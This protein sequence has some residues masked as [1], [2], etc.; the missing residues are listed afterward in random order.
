MSTITLTIT[1]CTSSLYKI[2]RSYRKDPQ[3]ES[4]SIH[5]ASNDAVLLEVR[6]YS[7]QIGYEWMDG[8]C[9]D[10]EAFY[11]K[12][13]GSD[14]WW[15]W[16]SYLYLYYEFAEGEEMVLK[17]R[18]DPMVSDSI[19]RLRRPSIGASSEWLYKMGEVP[20]DWY[21]ESASTEGWSSGA[22]GSFSGATNGIQL[23][24]Q[25]FTIDSISEVKGVV[26]NIR[27][28]Y[29]CV[30]YLNGHEAWRNGV[31]GAVSV[32]SVPTNTY[33]EL[34]YRVITLPGRTMPTVD[35][36]A[37]VNLLKQGTNTIAIAIVGPSTDLQSHFD[38]IVRLMPTQAESHIWEFRVDRIDVQNAAGLFDMYYDSRAT[39]TS[40]TDNSV[41]I[42]LSNDRREWVS[43]IQIQNF[44]AV[45]TQTVTQFKLYGRNSGDWILLKDVSGLIYTT[46][47]QKKRIYLNN[48][49]PYNQFKFENLKT[50]DPNSCSWIIQSLDLYADNTMAESTELVYPASGEAFKDIE[51]AEIIPEG[52]GYMDFQITPALPAGIH[53]DPKLAGSLE[54]PRRRVR[55]Q[56][57]RSLRRSWLE[58]P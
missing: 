6:D 8:I 49:T 23:Y 36:P 24:R 5:D 38:A 41:T 7:S 14:E 32:N 44:Y 33:G 45:N 9:I 25:S 16:N 17:A 46:A 35:S 54:Q 10:E 34:M 22:M 3:N 19:H 18:Y 1:E 56:R 27:Y 12:V 55:S 31:D 52:E 2:V 11:V 20:S 51:I 26:L 43:S 48:N 37:S 50:G 39:C 58:E 53:M 40:C 4:F 42:T 28:K 57:I 15:N 30:V 13:S 29:G 21:A 47:G